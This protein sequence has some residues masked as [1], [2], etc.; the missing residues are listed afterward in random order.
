MKI[1][2][3]VF[4]FNES[5]KF[6]CLCFSPITKKIFIEREVT[7]AHIPIK[8]IPILAWQLK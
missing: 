7:L 8:H 4:D 5:Y 3:T 6:Q 2:M 1:L